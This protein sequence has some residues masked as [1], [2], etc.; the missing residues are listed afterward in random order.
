MLVRRPRRPVAGR[1]ESH[2]RHECGRRRRSFPTGTCHA[3]ATSPGRRCRKW[4]AGSCV[5]L[6]SQD[7]NAGASNPSTGAASSA[8]DRTPS[9]P[10]VTS[11]VCPFGTYHGVIASGLPSA[12]RRRAR[13]PRPPRPMSAVLVRPGFE[14]RRLAAARQM[15][16]AVPKPPSRRRFR[17]HEG[18]P[19]QRRVRAAN[20][21]GVVS[22]RFHRHI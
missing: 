12:S 10:G 13:S 18:R 9:G 4:S 3:R 21:A 15:N 17:G 16:A 11:T 14:R 19:A 22:K 2:A 20:D 7:T 6:W 5:T 1:A 8:G